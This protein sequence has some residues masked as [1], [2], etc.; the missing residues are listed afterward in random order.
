MPHP[1]FKSENYDNFG[2]INSKTSAYTTGPR[3]VLALYNYDFSTIGAWTK[4]PGSSQYIGQTFVSISGLH[5]FVKTNGFSELMVGDTGALWAGTSTGNLV[6]ISASVF[7]ITLLAGQS[8]GFGIYQ[9]IMRVGST[10]V[11]SN[12]N[13]ISFYRNSVAMNGNDY[14]FINYLNHAYLTNGSY[15]YKYSGTSLLHTNI[16]PAWVTGTTNS[17]TVP[18]ISALT[19]TTGTINFNLPGANGASV[20]YLWSM[21]AALVDSNGAEGPINHLGGVIISTAGQHSTFVSQFGSFPVW[22][23]NIYTPREYDITR[24]N[25]YAAL[26]LNPTLTAAGFIPLGASALAL[27]VRF[28]GSTTAV[29]GTDFSL[30]KFALNSEQ[31]QTGGIPGLAVAE[32]TLYPFITQS[33]SGWTYGRPFAF[34][35]DF[36][37]FT[38]V[39]GITFSP[40]FLEVYNNRMALMGFSGLPSSFAIT[41]IVEPE[42]IL[43]DNIFEVRTNDGDILTGGRFYLNQLIL[44]KQKSIHSFTGDAPE[45][46]YIKQISDEYGCLNNKAACVWGDRLWFLDE[47][48]ICEFNGANIGIVGHKVDEVFT[49]MNLDAAIDTAI[50]L[51]QKERNEIWCGIPVDGATQNNLTVVYDYEAQAWTYWDGFEPKYFANVR[52]RFNKTT[53][54]FADY[55][56]RVNSFGVSFFGDN[57]VGISTVIKARFEHPMGQ[58]I[59]KMFRRAFLNYD[60]ITGETINSFNLSLRKNYGD[61]IVLSKGITLT[62]FQQVTNFGVSAKSLSVQIGHFSATERLRVY[63]YTLEYRYQRST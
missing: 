21:Y 57:G 9:D 23:A 52:Q 62:S 48:G 60:S 28:I 54:F 35:A 16:L 56:G 25:L 26:T 5:E 15:L 3:E 63:G 38:V 33:M 18:A 41:E 6:G 47:K 51:H 43:P 31:I 12:H 32:R 46:F 50:M 37:G 44:F 27:D 39:Q 45:N 34:G 4:R 13:V 40:R 20:P 14:D 61:S 7:G 8:L 17:E 10:T 58:S 36:Q 22:N 11:P 29:G 53:G 19:G 24:I 2:G 1:R 42:S 59:E 49:R 55:D 30:V